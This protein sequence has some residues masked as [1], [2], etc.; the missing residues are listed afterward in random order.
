M[1]SLRQVS[2]RIAQRVLLIWK[3]LTKDWEHEILRPIVVSALGA[4]VLVS[5]ALMFTPVRRF[6]FPEEERPD[7][8]LICTA[9]PVVKGER[10]LVDFYII[11]KTDEPQTV[12]KL[13]EFLKGSEASPT[14][15][16]H[17]YRPGQISPRADGDFNDGKADLEVQAAGEWVQIIPKRITARAIA[18]V[19]IEITG[20]PEFET[21]TRDAR[22]SI[23]FDNLEPY[24]RACYTR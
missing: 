8:P 2:R 24:E 9:E 11:N 7:Y 3:R 22:A 17:Y 5:G 21:I 19:T 1:T 14:I 23:P 6:L 10:L 18:R 13:K 4:V 15:K 20:L 12:E 16:L